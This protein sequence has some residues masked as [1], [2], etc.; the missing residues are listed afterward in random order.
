MQ[1]RLP[2]RHDKAAAAGYARAMS[3]ITAQVVAT[4]GFTPEEYERVLAAM[5][6]EPNLLELGIFSVMWNIA[7]I[8]PAAC[9]WPSCPRRRRG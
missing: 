5:G 6:R 4:H 1:Q 3:Q 9:T 2:L 7:A 8:N